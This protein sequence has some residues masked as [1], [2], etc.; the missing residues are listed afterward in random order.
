MHAPEPVEHQKGRRPARIGQ[1]CEQGE[2]NEERVLGIKIEKKLILIRI[3]EGTT[4]RAPPPAH[5][6]DPAAVRYRSGAISPGLS[7]EH[8]K[9]RRPARK[10]KDCNQGEQ[11]EERALGIKIE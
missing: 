5:A 4:Y 7:P 11:K 8:Q 10:E 9:E 2:K 1:D 6:R 3:V